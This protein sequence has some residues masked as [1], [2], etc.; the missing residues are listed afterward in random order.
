[1]HDGDSG[2]P[3][4]V[5]LHE[6][7]RQ[8][9]SHDH[10]AAKNNNVSAADLN[11]AFKEQTLHGQRRARHKAARII[12]HELGDVFRVKSVYV[13]VRIECAHDCCFVDVLRWRRLNQNA[14]NIRVVIKFFDTT[15]QLSLRRRASPSAGQARGTSYLSSAH[16]RVKLDYLRRE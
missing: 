12:E 9:F 8:R 16:R 2:V 11:V 4:F 10:A 3:V 5:F 7:Q 1:M 15:E 6:K 13:L 14:M